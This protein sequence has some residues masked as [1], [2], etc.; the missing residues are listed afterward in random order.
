MTCAAKCVEPQADRRHA[1]ASMPGTEGAVEA[2]RSGVELVPS[3]LSRRTMCSRRDDPGTEKSLTSTSSKGT[4]LST[5]PTNFCPIKTNFS[6]IRKADTAARFS[7]VARMIQVGTLAQGAQATKE[8][9]KQ[10]K[11]GRSAPSMDKLLNM[12]RCIPAVAEF[13]LSEIVGDDNGPHALNAV[14]A[15]LHVVAADPGPEGSA[16]RA[17]LTRLMGRK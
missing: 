2:Q 5:A 16:A 3:I 12:A 9:G 8:A 14:I 1:A 4:S 7:T 10:W 15:G 11:S 13:V 17:L 6:P